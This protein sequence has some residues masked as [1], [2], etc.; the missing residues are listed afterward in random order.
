MFVDTDLRHEWVKLKYDGQ[1]DH[2]SSFYS[3]H[4]RKQKT[5]NNQ[6]DSMT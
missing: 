3:F 5:E 2:Q 6:E 4:N 1:Q